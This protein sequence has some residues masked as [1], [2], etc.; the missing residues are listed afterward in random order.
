VNQDKR[1]EALACGIRIGSVI[2]SGLA[3]NWISS[4]FDPGPVI[5]LATVVVGLV[6]LVLA[7]SPRSHFHL[8]FLGRKNLD[9]LKFGMACLLL[10][11]LLGGLWQLPV[12]SSRTIPLSFL[13]AFGFDGLNTHNYELG[14]IACITVIGGIGAVRKASFAQ[15][16]TFGIAA[17]TGNSIVLAFVDAGEN[18]L[19]TVVGWTICYFLVMAVAWAMPDVLRLFASFLRIGRWSG[20]R[21]AAKSVSEAVENGPRSDEDASDKS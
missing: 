11:A 13:S 17:I 21:H 12:F 15:I 19:R 6:L 18:V 14:A 7:D 4:A 9:L 1:T 2:V 16:F 5:I 20:S 8:S 3:I 10:G